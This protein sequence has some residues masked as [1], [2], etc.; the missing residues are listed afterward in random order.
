MSYIIV[1][2]ID[3]HYWKTMN[4]MT[5]DDG[6][7]IRTFKT[8]IDAIR[9]LDSLLEDPLN[10]YDQNYDVDILIDRIH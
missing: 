5:T 6:K 2:F 4:P 1:E 3:G 9:T 10:Y 7:K 8:E